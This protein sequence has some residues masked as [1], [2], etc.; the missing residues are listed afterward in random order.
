V[1][2]QMAQTLHA[3]KPNKLL[4]FDFLYIGRGLNGVDYILIL[5]DDLSSY[6]RLIPAVV[7]KAVTTAA[8]LIHWFATFGVVLDWVSDRGSHFRNV[9]VRLLRER[10]HSSHHFT[11]AY[12]G[13]TVQSKV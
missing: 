11:L 6:C 9:V 7:A 4:H 5:K 12:R 10:N 1:R 13:A 3:D 8:A 2:R